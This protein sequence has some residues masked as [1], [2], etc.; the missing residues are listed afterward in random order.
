MLCR[1]RPRRPAARTS[2]R[3]A[4]QAD[5]RRSAPSLVLWRWRHLVVAACV[6]AAALLAL[7]V[8]RPAA[9]Q[10]RSVLVVVQPVGAGAVLTEDDVERRS[11]PQEAVPQDDLADESVIGARSAVDLAQ[12]TVLTTSMTSAALTGGLAPGERLVQVPV[13]IGAEL[14]RPGTRV[15][16]VAGGSGTN[17]QPPAVICAGARVVLSRPPESD[18]ASSLLGG[19]SGTNG[20][21]SRVTL[22]TLAVPHTEATLIVGAATHG[23]L[24]IV[25]SP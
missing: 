11:L 19:G 16:I 4:S 22:I 15:D 8:L 2:R 14:A 7:S 18:G 13:E 17:A 5:R 9:P 20:S 12:G 6:G 21:V 24:G 25:L 1:T 23:S 10:G 3:S